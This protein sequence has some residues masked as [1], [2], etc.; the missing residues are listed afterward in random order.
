MNPF[1][2]VFD[3][4]LGPVFDRLGV[5]GSFLAM[6]V[7]VPTMVYL[8]MMS[9]MVFGDRRKEE[10]AGTGPGPSITLTVLAVISG[11]YY[12]FLFTFGVVPY[13][14]GTVI[15]GVWRFVSAVL[16]SAQGLFSGTSGLILSALASIVGLVLFFVLAGWA[17]RLGWRLQD[18]I[19]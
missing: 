1:E 5:I 19:R 9:F 11:I 13:I 6:L 16:P 8:P 15:P 18:R 14:F 3:V 2:F 12:F 10:A 4:V 7:L 17:F